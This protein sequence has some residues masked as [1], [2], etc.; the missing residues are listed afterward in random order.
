ME[1]V[2]DAG[3]SVGDAA[4][5]IPPQQGIKSTL[6]VCAMGGLAG[7]DRSLDRYVGRV[8][9]PSDLS[10]LR[11]TTVTQDVCFSGSVG[12]VTS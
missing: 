2:C 3:P 8:P 5:L 11:P 4:G 12:F 9:P 7:L 10:C 1:A 6:C